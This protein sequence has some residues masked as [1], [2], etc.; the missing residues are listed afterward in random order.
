MMASQ[1]LRRQKMA[2][3]AKGT[4]GTLWFWYPA[5]IQVTEW[6]RGRS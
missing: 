2:N 4:I 6:V 1:M 5:L 3:A